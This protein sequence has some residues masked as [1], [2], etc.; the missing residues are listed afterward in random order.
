MRFSFERCHSLPTHKNYGTDGSKP[1]AGTKQIQP[2]PKS[3]KDQAVEAA[4]KKDLQ[5]RNIK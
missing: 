3:K 4:N 2:R 1:Q 5:Q